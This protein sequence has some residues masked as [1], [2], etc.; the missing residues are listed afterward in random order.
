[1]YVILTSKPGQYAT[2]LNEDMASEETYDYLLSGR[3][4]ARF[5]IARLLRDT[6]V[7]VTDESTPPAVN[8]IPSKLLPKFDSIEAA[9]RA[10]RQLAQFGKLDVELVK[11]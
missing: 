1:M 10:V 6:R 5:V 11:R 8:R 4:R 9:R 7:C 3:L 2:A